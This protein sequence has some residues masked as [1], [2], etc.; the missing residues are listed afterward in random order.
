PGLRTGVFFRL[1][2]RQSLFGRGSNLNINPEGSIQPSGFFGQSTSQACPGTPGSYVRCDANS[3]Y[4]LEEMMRWLQEGVAGANMFRADAA[5][6]VT[7]Y[8]TASAVSGR[9]DLDDGQLATYQVIWLSDQA[10]RLSYAIINYDKLGFDAADFRMN[11]RSGRCRALFNGGNHTGLVD[12]DPT[13]L[14]KN[15]PKI[16]AS[17]SGVPSQVRGRYMFRVDDVVRPGGCSNKTGGTYPMLIYP[18]IV[19]ML[20]EMTIDINA[21]CLDRTK[22]YILMIEQRETASCVVLNPSIARCNIPRIYDWGT[23]TLFFQPQT[24]KAMDDKAYV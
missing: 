16:L 3:D 22:T 20:G 12:V 1:V 9:S 14:Y 13:Q 24:G 7:W 19:N 11:S 23:K 18:N 2:L 8:N 10:A 5:V 15:S 21:M 6:I 4:F 17:R